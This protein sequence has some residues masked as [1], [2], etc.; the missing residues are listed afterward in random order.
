[1]RVLVV[2]DEKL[3]AEDL[4]S[5]VKSLYSDALCDAAT[6]ADEAFELAEK[7]EYDVALL[8]IDLVDMDGLTLARKLISMHPSINIIFVTGHQEY[9]LEAHEL[10]CSGFLLKPV[11]ER[12]LKKAFENLRKPL[13]ELSEEFYSQHYQGN[14]VLGKRIEKYREMRGL[15]RNDLAD[16]MNVTRQTIHRWEHGERIPDV[17][18]FVRLARVLGVEIGELLGINGEA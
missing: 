3:I 2:D 11:G 15:S 16:F 18:T 13:I 5:E 7:S 17:L 12:K 9:S 10:Y 1:M 8:D 6:S 4:K 14:D